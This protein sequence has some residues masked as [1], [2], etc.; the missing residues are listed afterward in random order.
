[1]LLNRGDIQLEFFPDRDLDPTTS[2]CI[3]SI[4]VQDVDTLYRAIR[5][6]GVDESRVGFPRLMPIELQPWGQRVGYLI[7]ADGTQLNLIEDAG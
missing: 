3:C 5:D 2:S 6:S 4:R 7:D 1:M